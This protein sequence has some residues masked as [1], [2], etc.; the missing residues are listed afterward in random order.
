MEV[1]LSVK[2]AAQQLGVSESLVYAW[3]TAGILA[4]HRLGRAVNFARFSFDQVMKSSRTC[5]TVSPPSEER[6][7]GF[8]AHQPVEGIILVFLLFLGAGASFGC[9]PR[10]CL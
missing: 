7:N 4:H 5:K 2:G 8:A 3:I 1:M 10:K 9:L 6:V